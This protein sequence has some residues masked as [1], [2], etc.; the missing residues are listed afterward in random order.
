MNAD[1]HEVAIIDPSSS[2]DLPAVTAIDFLNRDT[3]DR[4]MKFAEAMASATVTV[5][6]HLAGK[7]GDCLAISMQAMQWGMNPFAVAQKTHVVNGILGYEAQLVNAVVQQSRA[8]DGRFHYDYRGDGPALECRVGAIP[9]GERAIQWNE[10]LK[11]SEVKTKNSPLWASN[12]KQQMGYLQVKNWAR[13][14]TPGSIMGVYSSDELEI[15]PARDMGS[16][17]HVVA[18]VKT[19]PAYTDADMQK[20]LPKWHAA[21]RAG[22][23][24]AADII[25]FLSSKYTLSAAQMAAITPPP[26]ELSDDEAAAL[27]DL[28]RGDGA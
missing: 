2:N 17:D 21:I 24:S 16:V 6:K 10:W 1:T 18:D 23:K 11:I 5:P 12:P 15:A 27:A 3:L 26:A 13:Q 19:L 28:A 22:N 25:I 8:I 4:L 9:R 20:N 7:V 14:Y